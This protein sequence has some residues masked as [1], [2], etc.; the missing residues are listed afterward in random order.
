[1]SL[2]ELQ[3]CSVI[4]AQDGYEAVDLLNENDAINLVIL[5]WNMPEIGG[6]K[7][8]EMAEKTISSNNRSEKKWDN[9]H[10]SVVTYTSEDYHKMRFPMTSHFAFVDHWSK[11]MDV[12]DLLF[13]VQA[14]MSYVGNRRH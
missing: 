11:S 10:L 3:G 14:V 12:E 9:R 5:D 8:L 2:L 1:M 4:F 7:T 13:H 6:D